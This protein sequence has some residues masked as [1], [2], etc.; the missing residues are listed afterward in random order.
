MHSML[1]GRGRGDN[2][3]VYGRNEITGG[4]PAFL[5]VWF[6]QQGDLEHRIGLSRRGA[7]LTTKL[8]Q[9]LERFII[10]SST[11]R[12]YDL[13]AIRSMKTRNIFGASRDGTS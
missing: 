11:L 12:I 2:F 9:G 10:P 8:N 13:A 4:G 3:E 1:V 7:R 5:R 6:W